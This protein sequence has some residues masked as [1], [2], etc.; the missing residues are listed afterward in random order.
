MM[1]VSRHFKKH[2]MQHT[3]QPQVKPKEGKRMIQEGNE[4]ASSSSRR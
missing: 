1:Q 2:T 4:N 3:T